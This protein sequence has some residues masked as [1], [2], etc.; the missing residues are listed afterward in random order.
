MGVASTMQDEQVSK[1]P[2]CIPVGATSQD[3]MDRV[4]GYL[5]TRVD[6]NDMKVSAIS[7]VAPLIGIV[8]NCTPREMPKALQKP[9]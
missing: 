5:R 3:V 9:E 4:V 8:Y 7:I 6:T 2:A 1:I